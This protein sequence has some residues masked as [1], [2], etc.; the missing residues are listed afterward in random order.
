MNK[1]IEIGGKACQ[2]RSSGLTP[3]LYRRVFNRDLMKDMLAV[4]K[5]VEETS[6]NDESLP[7]E[8]LEIFEKIAF[9]MNKQGDSSQPD[10]MDDWLDQ[11]E[12]F[13]IYHVF[14]E[15]VELWQVENKQLSTAKKKKG[16]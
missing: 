10:N 5:K 6:L 2:F 15:L 11:F 7:I 14:P 3:I 13:D 1:T 16:Q 8:I 4:M 9:I 12:F